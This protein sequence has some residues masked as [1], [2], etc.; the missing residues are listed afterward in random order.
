MA[1]VAVALIAAAA[2]YVRLESR[3]LYSVP[4]AAAF[5]RVAALRAGGLQA[6]SKH[7]RTP[8]AVLGP[9]RA[10]RRP[11][12]PRDPEFYQ[13][14]HSAAGPS[15]RVASSSADDPASDSGAPS[16]SA[17][18][19]PVV[20]WE[21]VRVYATAVTA[22]NPGGVVKKILPGVSGH[23]GPGPSLP[24]SVDA[25]DDAQVF[26]GSVELASV[27]VLRSSGR[28]A[29]AGPLLD[30][31]AGRTPKGQAARGTVRVDGA[32]ISA[33][34]RAISGYVPQDDVLPGTSRSGNTSCLTP[35]CLPEQTP[36]EELYRCVVGWSTSWGS[37]R[38]RSRASAI[39]S[40]A[41]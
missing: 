23:A 8:S 19:R 29:R 24:P 9:Q 28:R 15:R 32:R 18:A 2:W 36:R 14:T 22:A 5:E 30:F 40:R 1:S 16:S 25:P 20:S 33:R 7:A 21:N 41:G 13:K 6:P 4:A 12:S 38:L 35:C 39:S 26:R 11:A 17:R 34:M 37:A 27:G 10:R 31:L 3:S